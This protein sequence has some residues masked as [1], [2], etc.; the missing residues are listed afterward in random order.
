MNDLP[1]D[2]CRIIAEFLTDSEAL[3]LFLI[4]RH[5]AELRLDP[6][7][8]LRFPITV[9]GPKLAALSEVACH[10]SSV[11]TNVPL[12]MPQFGQILAYS[13]Y[14]PPPLQQ[15]EEMNA[16]ESIDT[17]RGG[18]VVFNSNCR[19]LTFVAN[20]PALDLAEIA[21]DLPRLHT[22]NAWNYEPGN[23]TMLPAVSGALKSIE[24][25]TW[26]HVLSG[27]RS[28]IRLNNLEINYFDDLAPSVIFCRAGNCPDTTRLALN[29]IVAGTS[30]IMP[31]TLM[32]LIIYESPEIR[33]DCSQ[34][35]AIQ[36]LAIDA[37]GILVNLNTSEL[38]WLEIYGDQDLCKMLQSTCKLRHLKYALDESCDFSPLT[39]LTE[40]DISGM[41]HPSPDDIAR[42]KM[43]RALSINV[44][45]FPRNYVFPFPD[46]RQLIANTAAQFP[47]SPFIQSTQLESLEIIDISDRPADFATI[48]Q[49][50]TML[51]TLI[52]GATEFAPDVL[53]GMP[54]L[55]TLNLTIFGANRLDIDASRHLRGLRKIILHGRGI[56]LTS[57]DEIEPPTFEMVGI[58]VVMDSVQFAAFA[59]REGNKLT[60][61][62]N[63]KIDLI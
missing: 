47:L 51:K 61:V 49:P 48:L 45:Q 2:V 46:L 31:T 26:G 54:L 36:R 5:L 15:F 52:I 19:T 10:F 34:V 63:K 3:Q 40:L 53:C 38:E 30:I 35:R 12:P 28:S 56:C 39:C 24:I 7:F 62:T 4:N 29:G 60:R 17:R 27:P 21:R 44:T 13:T 50:L 58:T 23:V 11:R 43:L 57:A 33:A 14:S 37:A 25:N 9:N 18:G 55:R 32:E 59:S 16:I 42:L 8:M 1:H 22:L 6:R 41:C 20:S